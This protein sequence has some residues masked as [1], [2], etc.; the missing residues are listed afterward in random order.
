MSAKAHTNDRTVYDVTDGFAP[1]TVFGSEAMAKMF[2]ERAEGLT[3]QAYDVIERPVS[4]HTPTGEFG[5][6][7]EGHVEHAF[8]TR[9]MAEACADVYD[10]HLMAA[11]VRRTEDA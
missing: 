9:R 10:E 3:H 11:D 1:L 6:Y 7:V 5:V 2:A 8:G 4:G